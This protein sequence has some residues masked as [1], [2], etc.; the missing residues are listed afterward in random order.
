MAGYTRSLPNQI[1]TYSPSILDPIKG[2]NAGRIKFDLLVVKIGG[3]GSY[4]GV[5]FGKGGSATVPEFKDSSTDD[6]VFNGR[7]KD[8]TRKAD[9]EPN[10]TYADKNESTIDRKPLIND[11]DNLPSACGEF[12]DEPKD[13]KRYKG[14]GLK[15]KSN[16]SKDIS[17][18]QYAGFDLTHD[19]PPEDLNKIFKK[20]KVKD[21]NVQ[22]T[23]ANESLDEVT[24]YKPGKKVLS[25]SAVKRSTKGTK[26]SNDV[27]DDPNAAFERNYSSAAN[28][29]GFHDE[30]LRPVSGGMKTHE[31]H[32]KLTDAG[33]K[34]RDSENYHHLSSGS[35]VKV[36]TSLPKRDPSIPASS[37]KEKHEGNPLGRVAIVHT[38]NAKI[39][40][41]KDLDDFLGSKYE[42]VTE[43][44]FTPKTVHGSE[45]LDNYLG[46]YTKDLQKSHPL[47]VLSNHLKDK[48]FVHTH[49]DIEAPDIADHHFQHSKTKEK[50][51]IHHVIGF[52]PRI[53]LV[54][55][56]GHAMLESLDLS[57]LKKGALHKDLGEP[58]GKKLSAK[59]IAI[60]PGDSPL[61]KK[62]KQFAI[63]AKKWH[64]EES[65]DIFRSRIKRALLG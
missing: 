51:A 11:K 7:K 44:Y 32:K 46:Q 28:H 3:L 6:E 1:G 45:A 58:A 13:M 42:S 50:K 22:N 31:V 54:H 63:N 39:H 4:K 47:K 40:N 65:F 64:H 52:E 14:L 56:K 30:A 59:E 8:E 21:G 61:E 49:S 35:R 18:K 27:G 16:N 5:T 29:G 57:G 23:K 17:K 19:T 12:H 37:D 24:E 43:S 62:R 9:A 41:H 20:G 36:I 25:A 48:G 26:D 55:P 10:S 38:G 15:D 33:Y 2:Q 34:T 60:K 53:V